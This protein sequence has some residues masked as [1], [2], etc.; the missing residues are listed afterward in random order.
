MGCQRATAV[1]IRHFTQ[2]GVMGLLSILQFVLV[3]AQV[4]HVWSSAELAVS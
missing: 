4:S 1:V 2:A 3:I